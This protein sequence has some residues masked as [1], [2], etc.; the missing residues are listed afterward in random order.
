VV[1]S[2]GVADVV[3]VE[4][5]KSVPVSPINTTLEPVVDL[6]AVVNDLQ[7]RLAAAA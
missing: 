4:S 5:R 7:E 6:P 3:E 1:T 2:V